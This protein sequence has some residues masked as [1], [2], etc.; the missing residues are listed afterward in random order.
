MYMH[1]NALDIWLPATLLMLPMQIHPHLVQLSQQPLALFNMVSVLQLLHNYTCCGRILSP[2][3]SVVCT[4]SKRHIVCTSW[5]SWLRQVFDV[6]ANA[7]SG[8]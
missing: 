6:S 5:L 7:L 8:T 1:H 3:T 4:L 2:A